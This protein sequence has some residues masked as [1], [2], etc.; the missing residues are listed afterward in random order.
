MTN[1]NKPFSMN[2]Y[3]ELVQ[4]RTAKFPHIKHGRLLYQVLN[5]HWPSLSV[6]VRGDEMFDPFYAKDNATID[7]FINWLS[8]KDNI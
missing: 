8:T 7:R 2:E 3:M 6:E 5:M 1:H 4:E